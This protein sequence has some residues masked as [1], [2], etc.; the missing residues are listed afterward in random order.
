MHFHSLETRV[1][2]R[3]SGK[4]ALRP[5]LLCENLFLGYDDRV[6]LSLSGLHFQG[7]GRRSMGGGGG[8]LYDSQQ[9][10]YDAEEGD[11]VLTKLGSDCLVA[12]NTSIN[13]HIYSGTLR[14]K[15]L[16]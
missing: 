14:F 7:A 12:R 6:S 8:G 16:L 5:A 1:E 4:V 2:T 9:T 15:C 13:I 10:H 11:R 3:A